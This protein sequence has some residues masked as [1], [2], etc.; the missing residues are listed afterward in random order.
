[1]AQQ[2][3][4][5]GKTSRSNAAASAAAAATPNASDQN[6]AAGSGAGSP[7]P[8][9]PVTTRRAQFMVAS[10]HA[11]GLTPLSADVIAQS[12]SEAPGVEIV[13]TIKP[14]AALG[15]QA[16]TVDSVFQDGTNTPPARWSWRAWRTT[17]QSC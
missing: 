9:Q 3:E 10:H 1:M 11:P 15:L 4:S 17:R 12:L 16:L 6:P 2:P 14:P 5:S 8:A 13:K 7:K